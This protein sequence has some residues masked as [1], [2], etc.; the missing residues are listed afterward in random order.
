M[1]FKFS[2]GIC[3]WIVVVF[4]F[5]LRPGRISAQ[6]LTDSLQADTLAFADSLGAD[7][8]SQVAYSAEDSIVYDLEQKKIYLYG[9]ARVSYE[10]ISLEAA[11]I[12]LD[13]NRKELQAQPVPD[14]SGAPVGIP[15]FKQGENEFDAQGIRYNFETKKGK[16]AGI[17]TKEGDSFIHGESV[18]KE[19]DNTTYI[20]KG[21]YT[22][23][24]LEEPHYW[25]SSNKIKVIPDNKVVTGPA[26]MHVAGVPTP[27]AIPFGFFPNKK[28]QSSGI[29]FPS[30]GESAQLGFFVQ[31]G[32]YYFGFSEFFDAALTADI[33]SSGSWRANLYSNYALRYRFTG[34]LSVNYSLTKTSIPELPDYS[35]EEGFFIRWNH[36]RSPKAD[37]FSSFQASVNA[38]SSSFYRNN[39]SSAGNYLTNTFQ[40]SV[41]W[42]KTWPGKRQ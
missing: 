35:E 27:L 14:S 24:S 23:C 18:R 12:V 21:Y 31:N 33:Y 29:L 26:D 7:F 42:S 1:T 37:P 8:E 2:T 5:L 32:G 15:H 22:T 11:F 3:W 36:T 39:L 16:L 41:T 34:N 4:L 20:R 40:S 30:F 13:Y 6:S 38:G 28:S 17:R 9:K 25:I 19:T 10:D